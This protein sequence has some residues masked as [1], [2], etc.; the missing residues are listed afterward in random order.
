MLLWALGFCFVLFF[1]N[2]LPETRLATQESLYSHFEMFWALLAAKKNNCKY[3]PSDLSKDFADHFMALR[4]QSQINSF[5]IQ[6]KGSKVMFKSIFETSVRIFRYF[7]IAVN[8]LFTQERVQGNK[9]S[10]VFKVTRSLPSVALLTN[11]KLNVGPIALLD[12]DQVTLYCIRLSL[13]T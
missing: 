1:Y 11:W 8:L 12:L 5:L 13:D 7:N 10:S 2:Q 9:I 3:K 6:G 4:N